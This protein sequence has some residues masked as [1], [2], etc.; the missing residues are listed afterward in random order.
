MPY[1]EQYDKAKVLAE[2]ANPT[3]IK[4]IAPGVTLK[5]LVFNKADGTQ[6][7]GSNQY[8]L[9]L[10]V[11]Q[12]VADVRFAV[13]FSG[14]GLPSAKTSNRAKA[15]NSLAAINGTMC[16]DCPQATY[17]K[18]ILVTDPLVVPSWASTLVPNK[19]NSMDYIRISNTAG[20]KV[21]E[22]PNYN[23]GLGT[24]RSDRRTGVVVIDANGKLRLESTYGKDFDYES[25]I[26]AYDVMASG[27]MLIDNSAIH[28]MAANDFNDKRE[29]RTAIAVDADGK[30]IM[31]TIDG[32]RNAGGFAYGMTLHTELAKFC[33]WLNIKYAVNLDGGGSTTMY[34]REVPADYTYDYTPSVGNGVINAPCDKAANGDR[35]ER[36][37]YISLLLLDAESTPLLPQ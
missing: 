20:E 4:E 21:V 29:P 12:S 33:K 35:V 25:K 10:V 31:F 27:P 28:N 22:V 14:N 13:A 34:L 36:S 11:D 9:A 1:T 2:W 5:K 8:I 15:R 19:R 17:D 7:F 23:S 16:G 37:N 26:A 30:V 32:R 6:L 3:Y 18:A 24:K